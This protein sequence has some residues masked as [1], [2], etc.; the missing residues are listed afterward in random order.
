MKLESQVCTLEQAK[1]LKE[2]GIIQ[3]DGLIQWVEHEGH[4]PLLFDFN[5]I[6]LAGDDTKPIYES[7]FIGCWTAFTVAEL[8]VM[9]PNDR[10]PESRVLLLKKEDNR[11]MLYL[12]SNGAELL[13]MDFDTE[14]EARAA[15]LITLIGS[16]KLTAAECNERLRNA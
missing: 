10:Q 11:Y 3:N 5:G 9:L 12:S 6:C 13:R 4:P 1:R 16:S 7:E 2:L 14:A 8:G 15:A